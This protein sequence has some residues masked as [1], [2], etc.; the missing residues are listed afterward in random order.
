MLDRVGEDVVNERGFL[1]FLVAEFR[2]YV[3]ERLVFTTR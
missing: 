2:I 1:L 3:T